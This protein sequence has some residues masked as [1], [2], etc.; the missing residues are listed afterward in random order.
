MLIPVVGLNGAGKTTTFSMLTGDQ[1]PDEGSIYLKG[2]NFGDDVTGAYHQISYC[3]QVE[4]NFEN[5][6][7]DMS[8]KYYALISGAPPR[9][10][11]LLTEK[12]IQ[13]ADLQLYC[14]ANSET[15][16]GGNKRKL[17]LATALIAGRSLIY[18]DEPTTGVDPVARRKIWSTL[19]LFKKSG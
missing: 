4:S 14:T 7:V 15:L 10:A 5:L 2:V 13:L 6:S 3:P 9:T 11:R 17:S 18:L 19:N 8:L 16:S 1:L 12:L